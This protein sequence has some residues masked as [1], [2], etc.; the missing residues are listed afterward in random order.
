MRFVNSRFWGV[1][2]VGERSMLKF[3]PQ[4]KAKKLSLP[5]IEPSLPN[6]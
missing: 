1:C 3:G 4:K 2:E 6:Q 5:G